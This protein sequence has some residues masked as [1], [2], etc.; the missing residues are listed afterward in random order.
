MVSCMKPLNLFYTICSASNS[1]WAEI[2]R[3]YLLI[4][5]NRCQKWSTELT[6]REWISDFL[7]RWRVYGSFEEAV[8]NPL[9]ACPYRICHAAWESAINA[10]RQE[11]TPRQILLWEGLIYWKD[12]K[13]SIYAAAHKVG[14]ISDTLL[15][16]FLVTHQ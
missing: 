2:S 13:S 1:T 14:L 9:Q 7:I 15:F 16:L 5:C 8:R 4:T 12:D 6:E 11:T 10:F 3:W